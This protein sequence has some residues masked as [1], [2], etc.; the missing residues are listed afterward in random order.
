VEGTNSV[1]LR[2]K[3]VLPASAITILCHP[4]GTYLLC[5][6]TSVRG[7]NNQLWQCEEAYYGQINTFSLFLLEVS[8]DSAISFL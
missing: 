3:P 7:L 8:G 5:T 4:K 2:T 6:F 1:G